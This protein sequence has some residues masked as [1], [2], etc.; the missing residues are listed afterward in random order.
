M[1]EFNN[2][3]VAGTTLVRSDI[4]SQDY[5]PGVS[6]WAI[7]ANGDVEFNNGTFR[8]QITAGSITAG[9]IGDST[10]VNSTF[11]GGTIEDSTIEFNSTGGI[12]VYTSVTTPTVFNANGSY[13]VPVGV[14]SLTVFGQGGGGGGQ[15]GSGAAGSG[16][17]YARETITVIPGESLTVTIGNGGTAGSALAPGLGGNGGSTTLKRGATTLFTAHGGIGGTS[18]FTAGGTGS[19]ASTHFDGGSSSSLFAGP[20]FGGAG[21]GGSGGTSSAGNAGSSG[22]GTVGGSG[23]AS[24][25]GGG[26]GGGGGDAT[27]TT[28]LPGSAGTVPGGGGGSGGLGTV[29]G[30]AGGVGGKGRLTVQFTAS[31]VLVASLSPVAGTDAFGNSFPAGLK[32]TGEIDSPGLITRVAMNT[33]TTDSADFTAE[34]VVQSVSATLVAGE[35][36]R[37]AVMSHAAST[38]AT[39]GYIG[40]IREDN[41]AGTELQAQFVI[42]NNT[43]IGAN[44]T[45]EVYYTAVAS[46]SKTFVLTGV[47]S[48]G[49]GNCRLEAAGNRPSYL[50]IDHIQ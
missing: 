40:R 22:T 10:I 14:T 5:V 8:G 48:G 7:F 50:Y 49:A 46:G 4:R 36:Y 19:T 41:L 1:F 39:D 16:A 44:I 47:R 20:G 18:A 26:A 32:T 9:S 6:G 17:E 21:G 35:V 31:Q 13:L 34:T 25:S 30:A 3:L 28:G 11:E 42:V 23:A 24:V 37:V 38:T 29:S 15:G 12:F 33:V 27:G 43:T 2:D 45:A